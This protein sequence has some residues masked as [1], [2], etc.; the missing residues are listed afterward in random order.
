VRG[1]LGVGTAVNFPAA[2]G[3]TGSV[4]IN[5]AEVWHWEW[6]RAWRDLGKLVDMRANEEHIP[7]ELHK[8]FLGPSDLG[9]CQCFNCRV[10]TAWGKRHEPADTA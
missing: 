7:R 9:H 3:T 1:G 8:L 4:T 6:T 10:V 2:T 5:L